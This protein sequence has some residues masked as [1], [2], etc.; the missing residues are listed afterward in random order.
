[1]SRQHC[2]CSRATALPPPC[3][4]ACRRLLYPLTGLIHS[5]QPPG[6]GRGRTWTA[7]PCG[8]GFRAPLHPPT[9]T[10]TASHGSFLSLQVNFNTDWESSYFPLRALALHVYSRRDCDCILSTPGLGIFLIPCAG[11]SPPRLLTLRLY[12][13]D[14]RSPASC[15]GRMGRAG[16]D[17]SGEENPSHLNLVSQL[18]DPTYSEGEKVFRHH[19]QHE[20]AV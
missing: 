5:Y 6:W 4:P 17:Y 16:G 7:Q 11:A 1:M 9:P 20:D 3:L 18:Q 19:T 12:S 13:K 15:R 10:P 2:L 14:S 8:A